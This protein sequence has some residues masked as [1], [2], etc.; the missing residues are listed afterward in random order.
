MSSPGASDGTAAAPGL[1]ALGVSHKTAP[2]A[3]RERLSLPEGRAT[4]V[5]SELVTGDA[6]REAVVLSTCNRT[7]LY[8]HA[9]DPVEA[10]SAALAALSRQAGIP[11]TELFGHLYAMRGLGAVAHLF[12]VAAGLD[13]MIVGEAEIQGQVKRAYELALVEG[14]T[15]PLTNRLFRDALGAGKRV[16]A[17]TAVGRRRVSVASVAVELAREVL[18]DLAERRVLVIGAGENGELTARALRQAG[19][20]TTFLANRHYD[21]AIGLAQRFGGEAVRL[22]DLPHELARADI[23]VSATGSPHQIVGRD[24][25]ELVVAEREGRALLLIDIAVPRDID[26]A[27]RELPGIALYDMDD[28]QRE[29]ARNLSGREAEASRARVIVDQEVARFA[30]WLA[31]LEVVPTIAALRERGEAIVEQVLDENA[32]RWELLSEADRARLEV[33]ARAIVRRLLHEPTLRLKR[34][35]DGAYTQVQAL[36]ELFGLEPASAEPDPHPAAG[37]VTELATRRRL[38]PR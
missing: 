37:E 21:R 10:E 36:R 20:A 32:G 13:S 22:D 19:V 31:S 11:P 26:S 24:E 25:L 1:L 12:E 28:L 5:L 2:L 23:V 30:D 7:E 29:V 34:A 15:G 38:G 6:V 18:G 27:V 17:E 3:L 14:V 4:G 16:R 33:L 9:A 8:L 35:E